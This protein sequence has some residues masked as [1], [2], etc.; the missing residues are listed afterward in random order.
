MESW[1]QVA[2]RGITKFSTPLFAQTVVRL[3]LDW[4]FKGSGHYLRC[5]NKGAI[6]KQGTFTGQNTLVSQSLI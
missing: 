3:D 2:Y 6:K 4:T 1:K 5:T